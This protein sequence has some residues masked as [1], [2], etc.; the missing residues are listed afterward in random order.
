MQ[1]LLDNQGRIA[2]PPDF[3]NQAG[4]S[5]G[6][7]LIVEDGDKDELYLR[8]QK[9]A[10]MLL[11]KKGILV[12]TSRPEADLADITQRERNRHI[13]ELSDYTNEDISLYFCPDSGNG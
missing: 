8:I 10:P 1:T 2:I 13:F 3:A 12:I 7:T 4:L 9:E 5:K 6:M 11:D